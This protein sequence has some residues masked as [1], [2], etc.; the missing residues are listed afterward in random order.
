[1]QQIDSNLVFFALTVD[2]VARTAV[3][4]TNI[5]YLNDAKIVGPS[6]IV[7]DHL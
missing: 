4:S 7:A 2:E 5:W 1:M 3:S 6:Q